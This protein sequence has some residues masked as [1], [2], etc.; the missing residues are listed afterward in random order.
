MRTSSGTVTTDGI[1]PHQKHPTL[2]FMMPVKIAGK[3]PGS[4]PDPKYKNG[5]LVF[6]LPGGGEW[7]Q[8]L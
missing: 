7:Q 5:L 2:G 8:S 3:R 6:A 4:D 1:I